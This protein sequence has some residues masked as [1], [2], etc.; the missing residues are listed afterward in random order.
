[1]H[2]YNGDL[3]NSDETLI[4]SIEA[5]YPKVW[6]WDYDSLRENSSHI[7]TVYPI[8]PDSLIYLRRYY[9]SGKML[10]EGWCLQDW[11]RE[12]FVTDYIGEWKYFDSDGNC[13]HKFWNYTKTAD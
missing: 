9:E 5:V 13:Y 1:M 8:A 4:D 3:G 10:S 12:T 2:H 7:N 11:N 6:V